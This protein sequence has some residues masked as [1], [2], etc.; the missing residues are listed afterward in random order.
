MRAKERMARIR[1]IE[2]TVA[3]LHTKGWR[4]ESVEH[5]DEED[6]PFRT[7]IRMS[8]RPKSHDKSIL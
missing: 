4:M 5:T 2:R 7:V 3:K 8:C 6:Q 1:E